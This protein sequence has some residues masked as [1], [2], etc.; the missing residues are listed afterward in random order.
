ME[1][2]VTYIVKNLVSTPQEV[3]V[4]AVEKE[5]TVVFE[6]RV[7]Q[8][9]AGKV[10]GRKGNT[11]NALRTIAQTVGVRLGKRVQIELIQDRPVQSLETPELVAA[12]N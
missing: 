2:F 1:E 3:T 7:A 9:D 10:I 4:K 12:V 5:G 6:L 8:S 11:I